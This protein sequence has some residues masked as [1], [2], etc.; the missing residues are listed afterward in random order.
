MIGHL[1]RLLRRFCRVTRR[2]MADGWPGMMADEK[3][4]RSAGCFFRHANNHGLRFF[5]TH[6]G[7]KASSFTESSLVCHFP[8]R[9]LR[10][11]YLERSHPPRCSCQSPSSSPDFQSPPPRSLAD[12]SVHCGCEALAA[13]NTP[14][15][16]VGSHWPTMS[17]EDPT[18]LHSLISLALTPYMPHFRS[19]TQGKKSRR[20]PLP[21]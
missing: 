6:P 1:S 19:D 10:W 5:R 21:P 20:P 16:A 17:L 4:P 3:T 12:R 7:K 15:L 14:S 2:S 13:S 11:V 9:I 18:H 8:L